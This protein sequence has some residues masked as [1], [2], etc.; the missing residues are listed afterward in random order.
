MDEL[1]AG[2]EGMYCSSVFNVP[3]RMLL[4]DISAADGHRCAAADGHGCC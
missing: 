1:E 4:R 2:E 3:V